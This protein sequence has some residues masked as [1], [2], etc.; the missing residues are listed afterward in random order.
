MQNID[1][2]G[3][4][5]RVAG[6]LDLSRR[7]VGLVPRRLPAWTRSQLPDA[8]VDMMVA[9]SSGVRLDFMT[10]ADAIEL[11]VLTT[12]V[13]FVGLP[14]RAAVF[15]LVVDGEFKKRVQ[16]LGGNRLVVRRPATTGTIERGEPSTVDFDGLG[17][18]SKRIEIWLPNAATV[19]LRALQVTDGA[20]VAAPPTDRRRWVHYGSSISQCG[21]AEGPTST[22]P[23]VAARLAGVDLQSIGLGGQCHLDQFVARTIRDLDVDF[24]S[25]KLGINVVNAESLKERT[26][27]AALNGFLDTVR[28]GHPKTPLLVVS[29]IICPSV[30]DHPGPT[31]P[32]ADG[33]FGV[34]ARPP[35]L[36]VDTLTLRRIREIL[37]DTVARRQEE[38]DENL[39]YLSGLELFGEADVSDLPDALH[40]NDAGYRR[41][42]QRFHERAFTG[43]GVFASRN[44]N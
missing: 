30:E 44:P 10:D 43:S 35:E 11:E 18:S 6:A 31:V 26:F 17:T 28:D 38:G 12:T 9:T 2:E 41:M 15:D 8:M 40:P 1:L 32:D 3:G 16:V 37:V 13:A 29:P 22:W 36:A 34:V 4:A 19:A 20:S 7:S 24:I 33:I 5:V 39:H 25:L 23:A 21:E 42:G 27:I 14:E